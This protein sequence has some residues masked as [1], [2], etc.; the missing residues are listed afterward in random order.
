MYAT[1]LHLLSALAFHLPR[2]ARGQTWPVTCGHGC[3]MPRAMPCDGT[4][5]HLS[6]FSSKSFRKGR[7]FWN[8]RGPHVTGRTR[9]T[10]S[11]GGKGTAPFEGEQVRVVGGW[12]RSRAP[13]ASAQSHTLETPRPPQWPTVLSTKS[14]EAYECTWPGLE[15]FSKLPSEK[16][17]T[18]TLSAF[19]C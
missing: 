3:A 7:S 9:A 8:G 6:P 16:N 1:D 2:K 17:R 12:G 13:P 19:A 4:A 14:L 10:T 5:F 15:H 18:Q 11:Q